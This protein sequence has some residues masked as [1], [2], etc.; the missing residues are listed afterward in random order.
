MKLKYIVGV[1]ALC[2]CTGG[3]LIAQ[4][5]HFSQYY[6]SELY[7]NPALAGSEPGITF[8]SN[9][10]TQWRSI[11]NPYTTSQVSMIYPFYSKSKEEKHFGG[12]GL[13]FYNDK[14]G[15][16]NF[17]TLG[18]NLNLAYNLELSYRNGGQYLSFGMQGGIIQKN[19]DYTN[20]EWGEQFN[21]YVGFD[22]TVVP[23]ENQLGNGTLYPDLGFGMVY[24]YNLSNDFD[25]KKT[26]GFVGVSAYHLN[27]PNESFVSG[28]E[29]RLP[30]LYKFHGGISFPI[31]SRVTL[32]PNLLGMLQNDVYHIN[33]GLYMSWKAFSS[34]SP[35]L[36]DSQ[37][38]LGTWYRHRDS[39]I[40][41]TGL[42][43]KN[44]TFGFSYDFNHSSLR[45]STH[46][47]GAY[48]FSLTIRKMK[49]REYKKISTPR[50]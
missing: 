43:H 2:L 12:A 36:E 17:K 14:A 15:D 33:T 47:R 29:A 44:Y 1:F 18:V 16:G 46:G 28:V 22:A 27:T 7:L 31:S 45:H 34:S 19:V 5:A 23:D 10:R 21:P 35:L 30:I 26:A 41:S 3:G 48:E 13:S 50:I 42:T 4:D 25:R 37:V 40:F 11:V 9:Y 32:S 39:F 6:S 24:Y 49:S 8:G 20:L 38:I